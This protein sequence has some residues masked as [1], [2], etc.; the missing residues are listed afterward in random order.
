MAGVNLAMHS[1]SDFEAGISL[2]QFEREGYAA[3]EGY[4]KP[5]QIDRA[6]S[7]IQRLLA[8]RSNEVVVDSLHTGQR[9][10]W[11]QAANPETRYFKFNDLYL[12]S[13][14]VR[15]LALDFEL[16]S[17]LADLLGEP[18][19]LCNSLNFEKGSS[20]PMHIDSLYM[21]PR[22][23]H[24][25]IAT[26]IALEDVHPDSG[27]LVYFPGS[28]RI[29]LYTFNDGT[30]H[31]TR[32]ESA[33]W[34]DYIDVQIRLRGLK[35]RAF[36]AKKGDVFIWHSDLVHG[37]SPIADHRRTRSSLVCHY[38]GETDCVERGM[39]IVPMH[40]G[41]WMRRLPQPV[42]ADP[43]SFGPNCPFPE[44]AYLRRHPDVREAVE[45]GLFPS[46]QFHYRE[47]GFS[48]GRG[49]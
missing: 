1:I 19:V 37:G 47:F 8:E 46:G 2:A 11:A 30:H 26:W 42:S 49:V 16:T 22:T 27:P 34:Y 4:F 15:G 43:G 9:T 21:T 48:E 23:P 18:A 44:E 20:Q 39:D 33:D 45:S 35:E 40:G 12:M 29:P 25:L 10:F 24:S 6:T 7:A 5:S 31:A 36:L 14:E 38:F 28:H 41:H 13:A 3:L 17:I 32:E